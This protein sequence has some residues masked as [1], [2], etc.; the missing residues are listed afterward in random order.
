MPSVSALSAASINAYLRSVTPEEQA[1]ALELVGYS[2]SLRYD[3]KPAIR[4]YRA[5]L[6]LVEDAARRDTYE[7]L[8]AEH[9]FRI[10]VVLVDH[11]AV[12][13]DTPED[14]ERVRQLLV[15]SP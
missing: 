12:S 5:S 2:L 9:G 10:L 4:A 13:V 14:L 3:W 11:D 7:R 1:Y 6:A 8:L 15:D